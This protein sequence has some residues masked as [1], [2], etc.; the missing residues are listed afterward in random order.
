[1]TSHEFR[2]TASLFLA[3]EDLM[4]FGAGQS[5]SSISAALL[6]QQNGTW[7]LLQAG[8]ASLGSVRTR[9]FDF[10][11]FV[12]KVQ[13]N[14][15]RIASS[16]AKVDEKS[17]RER[18]CFLCTAHLPAEQ[19][20]VA[21]GDSYVILC[22]PFPI[23]PEHFTIPH[24]EH[25]PQRI[26]GSFGVLLDLSRAMGD[27]YTL[28]YNGPRCGAS[29]PDHLHFQA[30]LKGFM[31]LDT[32][33]P[34]IIRR[35][36]RVV[37]EKSD[38]RSTAVDGCLRRF[39]ALESSSRSVL[40]REFAALAERLNAVRPDDEE[41][42]LNILVSYQDGWRVL[43]FPRARHRPSFFFAEGEAKILISP[44]AVDFG[45]VCITPLEKDFQRL[46]REHLVEMFDEVSLGKREFEELTRSA[47]A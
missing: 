14:P 23:F 21:F 18:K 2:D 9:V 19:R 39:I 12:M 43:V 46:T 34:E 30:G 42:M 35:F 16:A 37:L 3:P 7:P 13:F 22:N 44:A 11:G 17:I 41:P 27:R 5:S 24:R 26:N 6:L 10:D 31:P 20:G 25:V 1:M 40:E 4:P 45:G 32:E 38:F 8:Y 36:G 29:A 33:Y 28:F 15:G 47:A